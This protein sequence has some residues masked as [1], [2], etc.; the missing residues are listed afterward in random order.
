MQ[1]CRDSHQ[2]PLKDPEE[3][4]DLVKRFNGNEKLLRSALT[5][6]I[7]YRKYSSHSIK[8][9]N[10]LFSQRNC[11]IKT[12][13][14]NLRLLLMKTDVTMAARATMADLEA[15]IAIPTSI[16]EEG[17]NLRDVLPEGSTKDNQSEEHESECSGEEDIEAFKIGEH[18]AANFF[19]VFISAK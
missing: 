12:L 7:R 9:N 2:G 13:I 17:D 10:P 18:I 6:E 8:F 19:D 1:Q 15:V 4:N 3:V 14:E 11:D 5:K 16:I